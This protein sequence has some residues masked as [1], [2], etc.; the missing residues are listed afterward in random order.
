[1]V[2]VGT[3]LALQSRGWSVA[4]VDRGGPGSETS[5]GNAGIIEAEAAE[6]FAMPRDLSSLLAIAA[7]RRNDV[8]WDL[9]G[10]FRQAPALWRYYSASAPALHRVAGFHYAPL[11]RRST[12]DHAPLIE[13]S[14]A[15][16]L[17]RRTGFY[18][19]VRSDAE[20][21]A[22][23]S[24]AVRLRQDYGVGSQVLDGSALRRQEPVSEKASGAILWTDAWS[25]IDP[26]A[27]TRAYAD[28]FVKRGGTLV[29]ADAAS[30]R[31]GTRGWT[32]GD[33][34]AEH[35][36]VCLGPWSPEFLRRFADVS[37]PM[38]F[39]RGYHRVMHAATAPSRPMLDSVNGIM[40][41][42]MQDGLRLLTGADL[43]GRAATDPRQ[44]ERGEIVARELVDIGQRSAAPVWAGRRPC[45]ADMLPVVSE[46][47]G[48]SG[49]WLNTGHGHQGFTL[50]PTTG[51]LLA[52]AMAGGE[53]L[54]QAL[55][56]SRLRGHRWR[57]AP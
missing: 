48:H 14:G 24:H 35:V 25:C 32:L 33:L 39:K 20:L 10:L 27:L 2:G 45:M 30:L 51:A 22:L 50:G 23:A 31:R 42:P 3:A 37:L 29:K 26:G 8:I 34:E 47:P 15:E 36:V 41:A 11:T 52:D 55:K 40:M 12:A 46:V 44:L 57:T 53:P 16:Q 9:P 17:I 56:L 7:G 21:A 28:L 5:Y 1:M 19:V 4:L 13:A 43:G 54:P 38:I 18:V 49:L 6:P